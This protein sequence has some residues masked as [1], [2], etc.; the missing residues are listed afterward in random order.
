MLK[1]I[2]QADINN[3]DTIGELGIS[4]EKANRLMEASTAFC[5]LQMYKNDDVMIP[6]NL[7]PIRH[8]SSHTICHS[9]VYFFI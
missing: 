5:C 7:G 9:H 3:A 4:Y 2:L 1:E 6:C 8:L